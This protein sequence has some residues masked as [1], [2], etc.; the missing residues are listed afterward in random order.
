MKRLDGN[1]HYP[2]LE[3]PFHLL[4]LALALHD[5]VF[6]GPAMKKVGHSSPLA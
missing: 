6:N 2:V 5:L 3:K 1:G 4:D